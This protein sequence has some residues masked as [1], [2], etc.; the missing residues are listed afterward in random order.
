[1]ALTK[2]F[3]VRNGLE[4]ANNLLFADSATNTVGVGTTV[5]V[6]SLDVLGDIAL[7]NRL[8]VGVSSSLVKVTTGIASAAS[9]GVISGI[10]TSLIRINDTLT[11]T[12]NVYFRPGTRV[13]SIGASIVN[14]NIAHKNGIGSTTLTISVN[15]RVTSGNQNNVLVSNGPYEGAEWKEIE[16]VVAINVEQNDDDQN[17]NIVFAGEPGVDIENSL[18]VDTNGLVYNP[19]Y[20]RL[21][22][23]GVP[24]VEL[25]VTGDITASGTVASDILNVTTQS[26]L[27]DADATSL[28]VTPGISNLSDVNA[29]NVE[30]TSYRIGAGPS[31]T[32]FQINTYNL[33]TQSGIFNAELDPNHLLDSYDINGSDFK[34][35]EYTF[36]IRNAGN[37]QAQKL[38]VMQD[39]INAFSEEYGIMYNPNI[40]VS[41]GATISGTTC[42]LYANVLAGISGNIRYRFLRHTLL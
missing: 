31:L 34:V 37:N 4:V 7:E 28:D 9:P 11:E 10:N 12:N 29:G 5:P 35:S 27:G 3:V 33:Y 26:T 1:M 2:N 38:L 42:E 14:L 30:A 40:I 21:G 41:I 36:H 6:Y 24:T 13:V 19:F 23:G 25:D 15:R 17:Y 39:G 20:N 16:S 22:I 18:K 8:F 32:S